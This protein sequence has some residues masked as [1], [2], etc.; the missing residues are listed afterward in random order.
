MP[1][2]L[3]CPSRLD[4]LDSL[5]LVGVGFDPTMGY[6]E[7]KQ[8]VGG[9]TKYTLLWIKL[10]VDLAQIGKCVFQILDKGGL[11]LGFY[12]NIIHI[13]FYVSVQLWLK[14]NLDCHC[15]SGPDT[16]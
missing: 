11:I 9:N 4:V 7:S 5:D 12:H 2:I 13:G 14:T 6:K 8:L 1:H 16:L 10:Q 15:K 3:N